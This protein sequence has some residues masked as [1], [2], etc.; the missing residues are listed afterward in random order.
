MRCWIWSKG[1]CLDRGGD[2]IA[3]HLQIF[4]LYQT[5]EIGDGIT[6][7]SRSSPRNPK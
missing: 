4:R 6:W 2:G 5:Q 7:S 1:R 3:E